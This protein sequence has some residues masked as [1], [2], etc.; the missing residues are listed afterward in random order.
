MPDRQ[1]TT[2]VLRRVELADRAGEDGIQRQVDRTLDAAGHPFVRLAAV[3][4]LH[5]VEMLGQ[6]GGRRQIGRKVTH[7]GSGMLA[8]LPRTP[9]RRRSAER[10]F[11][12]GERSAPEEHEPDRS[13][14][15]F[16]P[17][18]ACSATDAASS[19]G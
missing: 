11:E 13:T 17:R 16:E 1:T 18:T 14:S 15:V 7:R 12:R 8:A 2:V 5:L 19:S 6:A 3:D 9:A 10:P 4:D